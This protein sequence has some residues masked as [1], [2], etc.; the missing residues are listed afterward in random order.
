MTLEREKYQALLDERVFAPHTM[1]EALVSRSRRSIA[2]KDG[3][4][5]I[6]AADHTARGKNFS[7]QG[8]GGYGRSLHPARS[9]GAVSRPAP[10]GWRARQC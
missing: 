6:L 8:H 10:G 5:L 4:L 1:S 9:P 3:N 7:R 2:G